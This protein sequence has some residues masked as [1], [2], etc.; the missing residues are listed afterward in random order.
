MRGLEYG[1]YLAGGTIVNFNLI[2][3]LLER[4]RELFESNT[5][6]SKLNDGEARLRNVGSNKMQAV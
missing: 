5:V 2:D 4:P 3:N 1:D 6:L